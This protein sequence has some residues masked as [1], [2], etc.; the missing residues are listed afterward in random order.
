MVN[1]NT[2][3]QLCQAAVELI[4]EQGAAHLTLSAVAER[5]GVSK[6]GL[7]Y[8][9]PS[10]RALLEALLKDLLD[11]RTSVRALANAG[12]ISA[13][14]EQIISHDID[15]LDE[16]RYASQAL[17]AVSAEDPDLLSPAREHINAIVKGIYQHT[18]LPEAAMTILL[19]T[20]GLQLLETLGLLELDDDQR[21][22]L[23][24]HLRA[25]KRDI[26]P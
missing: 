11:K 2:P 3:T 14:L 12:A 9:F 1:T 8:H 6:G 23:R 24:E 5:A 4:A 25:G 10:K 20:E 18:H 22:R 7:L 19:A 21:K 16:E 15:L 17:L 13:M 26:A